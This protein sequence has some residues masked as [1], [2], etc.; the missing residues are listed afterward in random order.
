MD[1]AH[2]TRDQIFRVLFVSIEK[3]PI[4]NDDDPQNIY[5]LLLSHHNNNHVLCKETIL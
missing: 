5:L 4:A 3:T 2:S 1:Y